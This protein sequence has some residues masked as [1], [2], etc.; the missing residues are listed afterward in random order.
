MGHNYD[1]E[2]EISSLHKEHLCNMSAMIQFFPITTNNIWLAAIK[3]IDNVAH[4]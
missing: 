2:L 3:I 1:I 4:E